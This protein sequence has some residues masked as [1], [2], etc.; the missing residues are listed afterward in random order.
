MEKPAEK[1]VTFLEESDFMRGKLHGK[2][3]SLQKYASLVIGKNSL[4]ALLK[5]ELIIFFFGGIPGALGL[6]LRKIFFPK[7]FTSV[8]RGVVFGRNIT[9][10]CGQNI[11]LGD[12]VIIDDYSVLDGRGADKDKIIIAKNVVLNRSC[13]VQSKAGGIEIGAYSTIGNGSAIVSQGGIKIGQWVGIAGGCEV[14]GGLFEHREP[15]NADSPPFAR[16]TRGPVILG[17]NTILAYGAIIVDG[18]IIGRN[19]MIGPG[20]VVINDLPDDCV[21]SSRPGVVLKRQPAA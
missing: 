15:E 14:S 12:N 4:A 20:C 2:Q 18:V 16:Y 17:D 5:Y 1:E 19:C 7:L 13:I 6:A 21:I 10:R 3:S 9:I 8:G 11:I